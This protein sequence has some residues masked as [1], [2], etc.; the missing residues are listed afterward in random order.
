MEYGKRR[1][2]YKMRSMVCPLDTKLRAVTDQKPNEQ[3]SPTMPPPPMAGSTINPSFV[4]NTNPQM[5][6]E[7]QSY[8]KGSLPI[9]NAY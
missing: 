4:Q 3:I 8:F 6:Y 2:T 1:N 5:K 7:P 9:A